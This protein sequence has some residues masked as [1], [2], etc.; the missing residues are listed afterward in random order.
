MCINN[1]AVAIKQAN[2]Q[3]T[4]SDRRWLAS[5]YQLIEACATLHIGSGVTVIW[6]DIW[7]YSFSQSTSES[8]P[9]AKLIK[10][11]ESPTILPSRSAPKGQPPP[12]QIPAFNWVLTSLYFTVSIIPLSLLSPSPSPFLSPSPPFPLLLPPPTLFFLGGISE[13]KHFL[14]IK[15]WN[16][17]WH[18]AENRVE[19]AVWP[20][21]FLSHSV[22]LSLFS[23]PYYV[24]FFFF[25]HLQSMNPHS[26]LT[27]LNHLES[28]LHGKDLFAPIIFS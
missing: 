21:L 26:H 9:G 27:F 18:W 3:A 28:I 19:P 6:A 8:G 13:S 16:S 25:P 23:T 12:C 5:T 2:L 20:Y 17:F 14:H 15:M 11:G 24:S 10:A 4:T 22:S 1:H 7:S